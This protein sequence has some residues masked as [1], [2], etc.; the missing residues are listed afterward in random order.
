LD[1]LIQ[2]ITQVLLLFKLNQAGRS[3]DCNPSAINKP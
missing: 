3:I 1:N 2:T